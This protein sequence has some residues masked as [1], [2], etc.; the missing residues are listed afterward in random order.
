MLLVITNM[1]SNV[2]VLFQSI[3]NTNSRRCFCHLALDYFQVP[4][5]KKF[6]Q[7]DKSAGHS[8]NPP[9][10]AWIPFQSGTT[11][12]S[13]TRLFNIEIEMIQEKKPIIISLPD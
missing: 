12:S 9:L 2:F 4:T 10:S 11:V 3:I 13:Q 1:I 5:D 6:C 7:I 8:F